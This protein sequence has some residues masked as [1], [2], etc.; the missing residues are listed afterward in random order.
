MGP[1]DRKSSRRLSTSD[2]VLELHRLAATLQVQ[3]QQSQ[4][5]VRHLRS[6]MEAKYDTSFYRGQAQGFCAAQE[7]SSR[8]ELAALPN[9]STWP[10]RRQVTPDVDEREAED[11][12]HA[13]QQ[14]RKA[15]RQG[16]PEISTSGA[17]P[18]RAHGP[19]GSGES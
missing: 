12:H 6:R 5:E 14:S 8:G 15:A 17:G 2:E 11:L 13:I 10:S 3:L 4:A 16:P 18:S 1:Q 9:P 19:Q 7:L